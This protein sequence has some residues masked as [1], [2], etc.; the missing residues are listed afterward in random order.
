MTLVATNS[1]KSYSLPPSGTHTAR[2]VQILDL[3]TQYSEFYKTSSHKVLIGWE[4]C[5]ETDDNG[6]PLLVWRRYTLSLNEK[7]LLRAHLE[8][9]RGRSFTEDE[10]KGFD[11]HNIAD[12]CCLISIVHTERD[13]KQYAD[14]SAVMAL[15]KGS[16]PED[17]RGDLIIFDI[18]DFND[19]IF[20]G[21]SENLQNTIN[22]SAE[23]QR[24]N[25]TQD[26]AVGAHPGNDELPQ[27]D[28]DIPF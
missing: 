5:D 6:E 10:L 25:D 28:T 15:P 23:R 11:L 24:R 12:K 16:K 1:G 9:W 4:L 7:S 18:D 22:Q 3:G 14:V 21:F 17:R 27:D 19:E 8:S 20:A 2:C 26:R 13:R